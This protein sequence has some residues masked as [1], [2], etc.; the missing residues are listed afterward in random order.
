MAK[1]WGLI[2][3]LVYLFLLTWIS[4]INIGKLPTLGTSFDD[5]IFHV[6]SHALL[7]FLCFNYFKKTGVS[8]PILLS[9]LVPFCYGVAIECLQG[10]ATSS[11]TADI[12]DVLA[13]ILGTIFAVILIS[14][15]KNVK[16]N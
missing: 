1:I 5:K 9:A 8:R 13:N 14:I 3:L 11:R 16:L 12:Y 15:L 6:L 4:F 7:T 2:L 10:I